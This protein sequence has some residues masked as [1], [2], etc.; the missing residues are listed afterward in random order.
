MRAVIMGLTYR[1]TLLSPTRSASTLQELLFEATSVFGDS[2]G[3]SEWVIEPV[4]SM[5]GANR[6]KC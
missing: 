3:A 1:D 6:W 2:T 5:G 4:P